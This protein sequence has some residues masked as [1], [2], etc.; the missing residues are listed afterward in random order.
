MIALIVRGEEQEVVTGVHR[1]KLNSTTQVAVIHAYDKNDNSVSETHN[2]VTN[3]ILMHENG[4][5]CIH[6]FAKSSDEETK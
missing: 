1:A 3:I 5:V 2:G 4:E 6:Q